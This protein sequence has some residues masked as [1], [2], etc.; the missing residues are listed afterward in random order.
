MDRCVFELRV[1][2]FSW[3][4]SRD[5]VGGALGLGEVLVVDYVEVNFNFFVK[6]W[7]DDCD[8]TLVTVQVDFSDGELDDGEIWGRCAFSF[9]FLVV[10]D[11]LF[12]LEIVSLDSGLNDFSNVVF[13]LQIV[14]WEVSVVSSDSSSDA[15]FKL[16]LD[17]LFIDAGDSCVDDCSSL[18]VEGMHLGHFEEEL[19]VVHVLVRVSRVTERV[20]ELM[21]NEIQNKLHVL[22]ALGVQMVGIIV[23]I[24][25]IKLFWVLHDDLDNIISRVVIQGVLGDLLSQSIVIRM[26]SGDL[27]G[28][29][30]QKVEDVFFV[31][32]LIFGQVVVVI[33]EAS[34]ISENE[35]SDTVIGELSSEQKLL[36]L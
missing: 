12:V 30:V 8:K 28:I 7:V 33:D 2:D 29:D 24:K 19:L 14:A 18:E 16:A 10:V 21:H 5:F 31:V 27:E 3:L 9:P 13:L 26:D 32:H 22:L 15:T 25:L 6:D 36:S 11:L 35:L 20:S 34:H 4:V 23:Q 1:V 17:E